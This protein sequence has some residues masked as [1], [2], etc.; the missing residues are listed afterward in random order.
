MV[1]L[2]A[3]T[4][5]IIQGYQAQADNALSALGVDLEAFY[6]FLKDEHPQLLKETINKHYRSK[7]PSVWKELIP[8]YRRSVLPSEAA[9][10]RAGIPVHKMGNDT[11]ITYKG[12]T[13]SL[14][15]A[16]EAGL[17]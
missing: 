12:M 13:M 9:L 2:D 16:V 4:D 14:K 11:I 7:N 17:L 5:D 10:K 8:L 15:A 6:E 1:R 3:Y